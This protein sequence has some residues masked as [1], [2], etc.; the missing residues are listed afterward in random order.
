MLINLL[1]CSGIDLSVTF[2]SIGG[3]LFPPPVS[4][5]VATVV[6]DVVDL[7]NRFFS[8]WQEISGCVINWCIPWR[9]FRPINLR[10]VWERNKTFSVG[11][12]DLFCRPV[13]LKLGFA[14]FGT[15]DDIGRL[16]GI[17]MHVRAGITHERRRSRFV[18]IGKRGRFGNVSREVGEVLCR[19]TRRAPSLFPWLF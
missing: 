2:T 16:V 8:I 17:C 10:N 7:A 12:I 13:P 14:A 11:S 18:C 9:H 6:D 19:F 4:L 5:S 15:F 1:A 3:Q